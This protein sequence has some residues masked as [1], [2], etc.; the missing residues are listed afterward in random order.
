MSLKYD[1][2]TEVI[3]CS[4]ESSHAIC[5]IKSFSTVGRLFTRA[6]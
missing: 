3:A 6:I 4:D 2:K 5:R 1:R